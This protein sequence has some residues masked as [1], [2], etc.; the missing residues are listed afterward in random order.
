M[1]ADLKVKR[2]TKHQLI[3]FNI[4]PK[5]PKANNADTI[6]FTKNGRKV[7]KEFVKSK[8][9]LP[10]GNTEIITEYA[11]VDG[12]DNK[13]ATIRHTYTIGSAILINKKDVLFKESNE[14][15]NRHIYSYLRK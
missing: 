3:F 11:S 10:N 15:I 4:Y 5:E 1:P 14:W 9:V 2:I 12:N 8:Q 7:N 13:P 6:L